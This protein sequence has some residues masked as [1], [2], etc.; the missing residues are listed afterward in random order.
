[1]ALNP[2]SIGGEG[3]TGEAHAARLARFHL[4][5]SLYQ[6]KDIQFTADLEHLSYRRMSLLALQHDLTQWGYGGRVQSASASGGKVT[7]TLEES[8]PAPTSG[9]AFVGLRIPGERA[10]RVF[11]ITP[12]TGHSATLTLSEPWP[13]D[14]PLPGNT[15]DNPATD[16]L[17]IYDFKQ[18]PGYRVRVVGIEPEAD[19]SGARV[20][21][22]P[23]SPEFWDYVNTGHYVPP[24][25]A[26]LLTTRPVASN[27]K[28]TE[29]QV[30]QGNTVYTELQV[31]FDVDGQMAFCTY[32]YKIICIYSFFYPYFFFFFQKTWLSDANFSGL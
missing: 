9:N 14:A 4:A 25:N 22:V 19:L 12:F 6:Y 15:P 10:Y 13:S 30:T 23:E 20:R 11:K 31:S 26:S 21:V 28:I 1:V 32:V 7:L 18:T 17:W 3:I 8:V 29:A 2:A 16:T 5:Q 24:V 27:L